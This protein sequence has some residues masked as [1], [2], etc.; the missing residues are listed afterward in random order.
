MTK[1]DLEK[2]TESLKTRKFEG[3][4]FRLAKYSIEK[5][6][7][8]KNP[9]YFLEVFS[10]VDGNMAKKE[11][12]QDLEKSERHILVVDV[13]RSLSDSGFVRLNAGRYEI[14]PNHPPF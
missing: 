12:Y 10:Y 8:V 9:V 5:L 3:I 2:I 11:K 7:D 13:L 1:I 14:N 6:S 4:Q